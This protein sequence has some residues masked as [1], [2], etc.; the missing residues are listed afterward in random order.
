M[1]E[2]TL[3][4]QRLKQDGLD[5]IPMWGRVGL[6]IRDARTLEIRRRYE[7]RNKITFLAAD[8]LVELLA[9]RT[10]DPVPTRN[11]VHSM[12]MGSSNTAAA[13]SDINLGAF[14]IGKVLGDVGKV[15]GAPGEIQF[16]TT[17]DSGDA[18]GITLRE[19]GLFTAGASPSTSDTPGTT[20]GSTRMIA[21][22]VHPD[23]LKIIS[24]VVDYSWTIAFTAIP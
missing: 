17:L 10:T 5:G 13:R 23:V 18:N 24:I 22:Q 1:L 15:T 8:L 19:A 20:P 9:Q 12:R 6:V 7:I 21:R 3:R 11:L 2:R 16:V 4:T 14:A